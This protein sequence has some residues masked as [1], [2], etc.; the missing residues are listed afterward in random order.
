MNL[1][2]HISHRLED[3]AA[4]LAGELRREPPRGAPPL[5][6]LEPLDPFR[7]TTIVYP[8]ANIKKWLQLTLARENKIAANL[9]FQ[10]F[11][12][13]LWNWLAG[14]AAQA[15]DRWPEPP[16]ERLELADLRW[17]IAQRLA[18]PDS[19]AATATSA[20]AD[21]LQ[22]LREYLG[23]I[24]ASVALSRRQALKLWQLAD[25]LAGVLRE[26][27]LQRG[28]V[29]ETWLAPIPPAPAPSAAAAPPR[30]PHRTSASA[31]EV[32]KAELFQQLFGLDGRAT[33]GPSIRPG[34]PRGFTLP[35]LAREL[36]ARGLLPDLP[37]LP[38]VSHLSQRAHSGP[39][40][41]AAMPSRPGVSSQR[42]PQRTLPAAPNSAE[43]LH[44]FSFPQLSRFHR[45]M[46]LTLALDRPIH[47]YL[48]HLGSLDPTTA[49]GESAAGA[50]VT[51]WFDVPGARRVKVHGMERLVTT[52]PP[53]DE[54]TASPTEP[55]VG[56]DLVHDWNQLGREGLFLLG[57][58]RRAAGA[59][60]ASQVF[61]RGRDGDAAPRI[62]A[63]GLLGDLQRRLL[64]PAAST[65]AA[66][67]AAQA[68]APALPPSNSLPPTHGEPVT[69]TLQIA[70]C[71]SRFREVEAVHGAILNLLSTHPHLRQNDV[72]V[73]VPD[74]ARYRAAVHAVFDRDQAPLGY[75]LGDLPGVGD[76]LF[77]QGVTALLALADGHFA[78][79]E[80]F[81][82]LQNPCAM[83]ALDIDPPRLAR[84][85]RWTD[86]L[87]AFGMDGFVAG[88]TG[89]GDDPSVGATPA[90]GDEPNAAEPFS[91][92]RALVRLQLG[93]VMTAP[94]PVLGDDDP[95]PRDFRGM[96][97]YADADTGD[98]EELDRF[99]RTEQALERGVRRLQAAAR[100]PD[101]GG[102]WLRAFQALVAQ[103]LAPPPDRPEEQAVAD[104]VRQVV[105]G[106][107]RRIDRQR[108]AS[109]P[110]PAPGAFL[111]REAFEQ[112]LGE[113]AS[114]QGRYLSGGVTISTQFPLRPIPFRAVFMLGLD[115][116]AVPAD[117]PPSAL[118]L[119]R[120]ERR[121]GEATAGQLQRYMFL[122]A[123]LSAR[124]R[125][126]L[127]FVERDLVEDRDQLPCA[128]LTQLKDFLHAHWPDRPPPEVR[129]PL[130]GYSPTYF[131]PGGLSAGTGNPI[132]FDFS[133]RRADRRLAAVQAPALPEH[134]VTSPGACLPA[135]TPPA[136]SPPS[137]TP[138]F[139]PPEA[140]F[141]APRRK[142]ARPTAGLDVDL[143]HLA[144]FL[145][146]PLQSALRR[147][148][149]VDDFDADEFER[150]QEDV[151]PFYLSKRL[152]RQI[153][154]AMLRRYL[155][156]PRPESRAG[157]RSAARRVA[158]DEALRQLDARERLGDA[159]AG[160]FGRHERNQL[161]EELGHDFWTGP[162]AGLDDL[163]ERLADLRYFPL[164]LFGDSSRRRN[165]DALRFQPLTLDLPAEHASA[166]PAKTV[167]RLHAAVE[168]L[169]ISPDGAG[170]HVLVPV[171]RE[172]KKKPP[173]VPPAE[174]FAPLLFCAALRATAAAAA[175]A[176][177]RATASAAAPEFH[178]TAVHFHVLYHDRT[179]GFD[180]ALDAPEVPPAFARLLQ[181]FHGPDCFDFLNWDAVC[182]SWELLRTWHA[183]GGADQAAEDEFRIELERLLDD[184]GES[185]ENDAIWA[186]VRVSDLERIAGLRLPAQPA[187][188]A[189]RRFELV[190]RLKPEGSASVRVA[191]NAVVA[192]NASPASTAPGSLTF[193][194][195]SAPHPNRKSSA[196][197]TKGKNG[198]RK[199]R[200]P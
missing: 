163:R 92:R 115:E 62:E 183:S 41:A 149:G 31:L 174:L 69:A 77:A 14:L 29:V 107:M 33:A 136:A 185:S 16:P 9:T 144:E 151:E 85:I 6:R 106:L 47:L 105:A 155:A 90:P 100:R 196:P 178:F 44:I 198:P 96:I 60:L 24:Q 139:M 63:V 167:V 164:L 143:H 127:S 197:R 176:N 89:P 131:Q 2:V 88:G 102:E 153:E 82:L 20:A 169:W 180:F 61:W 150:A 59:S 110:I 192:S 8:N 138:P 166:A 103:F 126:Y 123:L 32:A 3:L 15:P 26:T 188:A 104:W 25:T 73:L 97:P 43:P 36:D 49:P 11:D 10:F 46:L 162:D 148:A 48:L 87:H 4:A 54:P 158:L 109:P 186:P 124:E 128:L 184:A 58:D 78:R 114:R 117:Q 68:A 175:A 1:S 122:E 113:L 145:R 64:R 101:G 195:A 181:A 38:P 116:E 112:G 147:R 52:A 71:P 7:P 177:P 51:A 118:D 171:A 182:Q 70:R 187:Q 83:A 156:G 172:L 12:E 17:M 179:V 37:H 132:D 22:P 5:D 189:L 99:V 57:E 168:H 28:E 13:V 137:A 30:D 19:A 154:S 53:P 50:P 193:G 121:L 120:T 21:R 152:R 199:P 84:W 170:A 23:P 55:A 40:A 194:G 119:T 86:A 165:P 157:A 129:V 95:L 35:G 133:F 135:A 142:P 161:I 81:D 42:A 160:G 80:V 91:W 18:A 190:L 141:A 56:L 111:V 173:D 45:R 94:P 130:H 79:S 66:P 108:D 65:A 159:P 140:P 200:R 191:G 134:A 67:A 27:E 125:L 72:L 76:S 146:R 74:M 93:R 34:R 98:V 39:R 75:N